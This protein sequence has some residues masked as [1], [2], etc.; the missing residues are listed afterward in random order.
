M[1][2]SVVL[3]PEKIFQSERVW[4]VIFAGLLV[5]MCLGAVYSWGVFLFP[6]QEDTGWGRSHVSIA[7]SV[8]LLVFSFSM[9]IAGW[10]ERRL[11]PAN[12]VAIGAVT[13]GLGWVLASFS[14]SPLHLYMSYGFLG[15][16]G[17][18]LCY[19]PSLSC[20]MKWFPQKKGFVSGI[21]IFGFAL[22]AAV[23]APLLTY[24]VQRQGW[25][26]TMLVYG[27]FLT[28]A[29]VGLSRLLRTPISEE[30]VSSK[31]SDGKKTSWFFVPFVR[32]STLAILFLTY[33]LSM[34]S[35]MMIM[36]H[37]TAFLMDQRFSAMQGA[38]ALTYFSLGNGLGRIVAGVICDCW[39]GRAALI[40]LFGLMSISCLALYYVKPLLV[41]YGFSVMLGLSFGGFL[42]AHPSLC[43]DYF[44]QRNF[45]IVYGLLFIGYGLGCFLGPVLGGF[46]YD[47]TGNYQFAFYLSSVL[48]G[49]GGVAA[50]LFLS[51]ESKA[52]G[53]EA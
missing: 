24:I 5:M 31:R 45:S 32:T 52:S 43:V 11:G 36:G 49:V 39:G 23:M 44:G 20:G 1:N 28:C 4:L 15:G 13:L 25:R 8:L 26:W 34:A 12:T 30:N 50:V 27:L 53:V 21:I 48:A 17:T 35:G 18:G 42:V 41:I 14:R 46:I 3:K 38:W 2:M 40:A 22:G 10:C 33:F 19:M 9:S 6:I 7:V 47:V 51:A 16:V 37:L 29:I